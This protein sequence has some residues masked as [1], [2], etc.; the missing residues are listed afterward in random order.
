MRSNNFA[1]GERELTT[2]SFQSWFSYF[3]FYCYFNVLRW[4]RFKFLNSDRRIL[5]LPLPP[6]PV[7]AFLLP[8]LLSSLLELVESTESKSLRGCW[9]YLGIEPLTEESLSLL[10]E[11]SL[12]SRLSLLPAP[13]LNLAMVF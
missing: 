11:E 6:T 13:A 7:L 9:G 10:L 12:L 3:F 2:E 8:L 1:N 4:F 5:S